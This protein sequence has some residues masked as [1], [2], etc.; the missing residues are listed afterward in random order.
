MVDRT[1]K[2]VGSSSSAQIRTLIDEQRQMI[3]AE[4][5]EK[6]SHHVLQAARAEQDRQILREEL[7]RQQ[8]YFREVHQQNVTEMEE[9]RKF[10]SSTYDDARDAH[11]GPEHYYGIIWKITRIA[12]WSKLYETILKIFRMLSRYAVEIL[13]L[14][15]NRGYSLNILFLKDC[16]GLHSDRRAAKKGCQTFGIHMVYQETFLQIHVLPLQLLILKNWVHG[17]QPLRNRFTCLQWRRVNERPETRPTSDDA[18]LDRQPKIQSSSVEETLQ[19]IMGQTNNRLQ[20]SKLRFDKFP[21]PATFACWKI[22]FKT[23]VCTC[24]QFPTEAMRWIKEVELV[25]SVDELRSS[26]STRGISMPINEV[27]WCEDCFSTEQNHP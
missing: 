2:P 13:T 25:D 9:L 3:I 12:K 18:N 14:P 15:V 26:S 23:E 5:C 21:T 4:C 10:Q 11:R 19:R 6:I 1:G 27:L 22:R 20:I 8:K 16:W 24:S 17:G 7:W